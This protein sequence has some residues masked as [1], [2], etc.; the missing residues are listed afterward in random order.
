MKIIFYF[1]IPIL[2]FFSIHTVNASNSDNIQ[3]STDSNYI[4]GRGFQFTKDYVK[5]DTHWMSFVLPDDNSYIENLALHYSYRFPVSTSKYNVTFTIATLKDFFPVAFINGK[6]CQPFYSKYVNS[7][8]TYYHLVNY[9]CVDLDGSVDKFELNLKGP[10]QG[11]EYILVDH[12]FNITRFDDSSSAINGSLNNINSSINSTNSKLDDL[13]GTLNNSD[14]SDSQSELENV[15]DKFKDD[16]SKSPIS[17]L[18]TLPLK[19]LT[20]FNNKLSSNQVCT[21]YDMGTIFGIHWL[22]LPCINPPDYLGS[23]LWA[24]IDMISTAL[25]LWSIAHKMVKVYISITSVDGQFVTKI[26]SQ[27]GGM[28]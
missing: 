27:T 14:T 1:L 24:T 22:K 15:N 13:N 19:L 2:S 11:P 6:A 18:I 17:D 12:D 26:I 7:V 20:A 3:I 25:L 16:I 21:P 28:L 23:V 9:S 5:L 4:S 10:F 8:D